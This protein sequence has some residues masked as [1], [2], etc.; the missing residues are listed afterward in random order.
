MPRRFSSVSPM[1]EEVKIQTENKAKAELER[2]VDHAIK[3]AIPEIRQ[4]ML[5]NL[6]E[7][8]R[9][10]VLEPLEGQV[11]LRIYLYA[12]GRKKHVTLP[13]SNDEAAQKREAARAAKKQAKAG[14]G[15]A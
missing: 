9:I 4:K 5:D 3:E 6:S 10:D 15:K 14:K 12:R 11:E 2:V 8:L 1:I 13:N 7:R